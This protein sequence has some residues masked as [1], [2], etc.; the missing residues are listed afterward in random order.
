MPLITLPPIGVVRSPYATPLDAPRQGALAR[1]ESVLD[2]DAPYAAGLDGIEPGAR[3]LVL[4]FAHLA[5]RDILGRPGSDGVFAQ[6]TIHRPN[7]IG[8]SEVTVTARE[9]TRL[10]VTGL[11]AVDGSPILD[12]KSAAAEAIGWTALPGVP[13]QLP[14]GP[15]VLRPARPDDAL[16]LHALRQQPEV[17][18][19]VGALRTDTLEDTRRF[20]GALGPDRHDVV[21]TVAG[22][23]VGQAG[24]HVRRGKAHHVGWVGILVAEEWHGRGVGRALMAELLRRADERGLVRLELDVVE[25][26]ER[27]IA[28][29]RR[30][31]F[32]EEGRKRKAFDRDG[33]LLDLVFMA[34]VR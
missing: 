26:N 19:Y 16:A 12:V 34:R 11:D 8:I 6:R 13:T 7:P 25:D 3:L 15:L 2:I 14:E 1:A 10:T 33:K 30:L 20:L 9:G 5:E 17:F 18:P 29:Y 32:V 28:W 27:A 4:W 22:E 31:G 24:L 21:A 23:V